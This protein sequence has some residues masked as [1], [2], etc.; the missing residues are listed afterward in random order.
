MTEEPTIKKLYYDVVKKYGL[1]TFNNAVLQK[2]MKDLE[3]EVGYES[4]SI[5]L[6]ALLV[7]DWEEIDGEYK[8]T[9]ANAL[10]IYGKRVKIMHFLRENVA[11]QPKAYTPPTAEELEAQE[12][13]RQEDWR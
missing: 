4:A 2:K 13:A 3:R 9:L 6:Q 8:P 1:P 12:R 10:D 11:A 5:Y 7:Y